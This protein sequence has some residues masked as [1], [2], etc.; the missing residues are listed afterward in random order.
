MALHE[1]LYTSAANRDFN[2]HELDELLRRAREK[3]QR[4]QITGM[5]VYH[6][7][8]FMQ[9]LEG[10]ERTVRDLYEVIAVDPRHTG[11]RVFY[12]GEIAQ[13]GFAEWTMAYT[14]L[15]DIDPHVL[16]GFS[17]FLTAGF[18]SETTGPQLSKA[19]RLFE[20]L[21]ETL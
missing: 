6:N 21:R 20:T 1:L 18:T 5:L 15:H 11:A 3:N 14:S 16:E 7:R 19:Q 4:L 2:A 10:E 9:I 13:R 8:E 12:S 17:E